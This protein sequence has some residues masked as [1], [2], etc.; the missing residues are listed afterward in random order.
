MPTTIN[1]DTGVVFPDATTQSSAVT[2][3]TPLAVTGNALGGAEIRLPEDTDNGANYVAVKAPNNITS[4]LTFTLPALDG[5]N[6]QYL[7]TNGSGTLSFSSVVGGLSEVDMWAITAGGGNAGSGAY[8][9]IDANIS[10]PSGAF[11]KVGTGMSFLSGVFTFPSTGTW[12]IYIK[13]TFQRSLASSSYT[14][15]DYSTDSGSTWASAGLQP[16]NQASVLVGVNLEVLVTVTNTS[17]FKVRWG[18]TGALYTDNGGYITFT[19]L[20]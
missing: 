18:Y 11:T 8:N 15:V 13:G 14:S 19:K 16:Y 4:N 20:A 2:L 10:R 3:A 1:G 7:Q 9:V 12:K 17:T 6:G 5:T